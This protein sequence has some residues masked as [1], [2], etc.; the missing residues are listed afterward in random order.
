MVSRIPETSQ[1]ELRIRVLSDRSVLVLELPDS[2]F[3]IV[4]GVGVNDLP[5]QRRN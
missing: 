1:V 2:V 5:R 4:R 3:D